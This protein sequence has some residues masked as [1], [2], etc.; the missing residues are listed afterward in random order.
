[1]KRHAHLIRTTLTA[2]TFLP[3]LCGLLALSACGGGGSTAQQPPPASSMRVAGTLTGTSTTPQ[4]NQQPVKVASAIVTVNGQAA[5]T[6]RLQP[7]VVILG[8][9]TRTAQ[10]I[11]LQSADVQSE[12]KGPISALSLTAGTMTVLDT[13]V[14]VNALTRLEQEGADHTFTDLALADFAVGDL[15]SVFGTGRLQVTSWPPAS[16]GKCRAPAASPK[17]AAW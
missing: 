6:A 8:R 10:G 13:L 11:T 2:F 4:F 12:L 9:A 16:N 17:P 1:M 5:T 3:V 14:T 15:V 7:G